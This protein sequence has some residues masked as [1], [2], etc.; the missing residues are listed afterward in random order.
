MVSGFIKR[1]IN[2]GKSLGEFLKEK[3]IQK[4]MSLE[5][6]ETACKV[7]IKYLAALEKGNWKAMPTLVYTRGFV[8]AYAKCLGID[9]KEVEDLFWNEYGFIDGQKGSDLSYKK[10]LDYKKVKVTPKLIAYTVFASF[11]LIMFGYIAY[12]IVSFAGSPNL[13]LTTPHNNSIVDT[14][15][16]DVKGTTDSD[17][18]LTVNNETVPVTTDGHF[19][20][21]LKLQRGINVVRVKAINRA[22]KE[23]SEVL[24]IEYK[25]QTALIDLRTNR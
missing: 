19:A 16:V 4:E 12:Q 21:N 24:T 1:K 10:L 17:I 5:D 11:L 8:L 20:T 14:D 18:Y 13:R 9:S 22:K 25:P 6:A 7:R 2:T 15:S 3:R 23:T